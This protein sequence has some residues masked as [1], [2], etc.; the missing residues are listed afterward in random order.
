[1]DTTNYFNGCHGAASSPGRNIAC[2]QPGGC[3]RTEAPT[4]VLPIRPGVVGTPEETEE[5]KWERVAL[6]KRCVRAACGASPELAQLHIREALYH[7]RGLGV[8]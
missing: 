4:N 1:M 7:L 5:S 2:H 6:A 8:E 3:Q